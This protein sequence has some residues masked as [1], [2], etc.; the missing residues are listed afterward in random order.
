MIIKVT[1]INTGDEPLTRPKYS[2]VDQFG[3]YKSEL[4]L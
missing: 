3:L 2:L 4:S 1:Q